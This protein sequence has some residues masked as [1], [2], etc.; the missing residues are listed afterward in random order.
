MQGISCAYCQGELTESD[1]GDVDHFR[2]KA[3]YWWLAYE[4]S[5]YF[6]SCRRCNSIRK[7]KRFPLANGEAHLSFGDGRT[8]LDERK[9]LLDPCQDDVEVI[10]LQRE[11]GL[12]ILVPKTTPAGP[13]PQGEAT[14]RFFELNFGLLRVHRHR[15]IAEALDKAAL[16]RAGEDSKHDRLDLLRWASRFSPFGTFVRRALSYNGW[17]SD[18]LPK[19]RDEVKMLIED[20]CRE[21]EMGIEAGLKLESRHRDSLYLRQA[22]LWA[23]AALWLAPPSPVQPAEVR[24]WIDDAYRSDVGRLV[25]Q[26]RAELDQETSS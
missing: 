16:I 7:G 12:W 25:D 19:P 13:D 6:L 5:N 20:L 11:G 10:V 8:E 3:I 23:L 9:L 26:L 2:P 15:R 14:I 21:L 17:F 4:F 1:R 24:S 18:L 22:W